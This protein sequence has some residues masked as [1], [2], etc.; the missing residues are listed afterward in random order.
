MSPPFCT[1]MDMKSEER[2]KLLPASLGRALKRG[3]VDAWD[4]FGLVIA[5]S[6][7]WSFAVFVPVVV[8]SAVQ[9]QLPRTW[10]FFTSLGLVVAV[11]IGTPLLAGVYHLAYKVV[12]R[13]DPTLGDI[14]AGFRQMLGRSYALVAIDVIA[15][16]LFVLDAAFFFGMFGPIRGSL[17]FVSLGV[18][19]LYGLLAW[20]M[21]AMYQFPLLTAQ[22]PMG[23]REGTLSAVKKSI[24]LFAHN[25]GFTSGVF[26]V[27]LGFSA[28]CA[29]SFIG[30]LVLYAGTV[31][32][33][34][35][36]A[37]RELYVRYGVVEEPQESEED[38][39]WRV[40]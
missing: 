22:R 3:F 20:S 30:M 21:A 33:V 8:A 37:L 28:L 27:I 36:H 35:T 29:V 16:A 25:P 24:L 38:T 15:V 18:L 4:R 23:Q 17:L 13:D 19:C 40:K 39:G 1:S 32:I 7:I 26:V 9:R 6:F 31:S 14:L 2:A 34:L 10:P 12:Y 11:L 5:S